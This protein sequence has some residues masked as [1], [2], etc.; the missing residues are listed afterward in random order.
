[1][2]QELSIDKELRRLVPP[3]SDEDRLSLTEEIF[4]KHKSTSILAW[5]NYIIDGFEIYEIC[6]KHG[7]P[8]TVNR[9]RF[10]SRSDVISWICKNQ[11]A[12]LT[13]IEETRRYLLGKYY[14]AEKD[15]YL[16]HA[17]SS[18]A[19]TKIRTCQYKIADRIGKEY[20]LSTSTV[21]KYGIYARAIDDI[22]GKEP[23]V[24]ER[25]LSGRLK[26]SHNN[27]IE[28]SRL[29]KDNLRT[30]NQHLSEHEIERIS[31]SEMRHELQWKKLPSLPPAAKVEPQTDI[32]IKQI[33]KFDPDAEI[34][35]LVLTIPSWISSIARIR[36]SPNLALSSENA[37]HNLG[38]RLQE[39]KSNVDKL[40]LLMEEN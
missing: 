26:V 5:Q 14:E 1:M 18:G 22:E 2:N 29:P 20:H 13:L 17:S 6:E 15:S 8:Y 4:H 40:L 34:S 25:I 24:V 7:L 31:Y 27:I 16:F 28:L 21:Y 23:A 30:L 38:E 35:S 33:P 37:R 36:N 9:K 19:P 32:P 39:L 12:K 10:P 11:L 3:L